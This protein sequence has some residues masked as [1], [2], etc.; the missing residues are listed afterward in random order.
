LVIALT[1]PFLVLS[2]AASRLLEHSPHKVCGHELN[3]SR[4]DALSDKHGTVSMDEILGNDTDTLS[5]AIEVHEL[6]PDITE[7]ILSMFF[8]N[9]KRSGG[10]E[11][12]DMF[13]CGEERRAVITFRSPEGCM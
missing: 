3:I 13:Y 2:A 11:I 8:Q 5:C 10:D 4:V 1:S 12:E 6:A 7:E 9:R